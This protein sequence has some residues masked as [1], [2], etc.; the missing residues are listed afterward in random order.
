V[1]VAVV[2]VVAAEGVIL[3]FQS[4]STTLRDM[5]V[6]VAEVARREPMKK[7]LHSI[8]GSPR[9]LLSSHHQDLPQPIFFVQVHPFLLEFQPF[10]ITQMKANFPMK[11]W[12]PNSV[13]V[14]SLNS[15]KSF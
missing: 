11:E 12:Y 14:A 1:V 7:L 4:F 9:L 2:A 10:S 6:A 13:W 3:N 15:S 8:K 5:V